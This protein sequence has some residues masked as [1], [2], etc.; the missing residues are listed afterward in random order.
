MRL[1]VLQHVPFEGPARIGDWARARGYTLATS[2][3]YAG[4][5]LPAH[6]DYDLLIVMGGP[7]SVNDERE[8]PWLVEEK[9][10]VARAL[11]LERRIFGVCLGAQ[12]IAA[13]SGC[14]VYPGPEKEIGWFAVQPVDVD[15]ADAAAGLL[16]GDLV[17]LHWHGETFDL[18]AGARRLA[19][20]LPCPNQ[21]FW[22]G[23]RALAL[24]FHI[25]ATVQ[26]V[27]ALVE[28]AQDDITGGAF[29]QS[30]ETILAQAAARTA[31]VAPVLDAALDRLVSS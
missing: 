22:L 10:F 27:Q 28:H 6:E 29:Q 23:R 16:P 8:H 14:R 4:D 20:T 12:L 13:A 31:A 26:S 30:P 17:P 24:Q 25:E 9:R 18:P 5:P 3:L 1:H 11:E 7:M 15:A 21:A 2:H 19:E